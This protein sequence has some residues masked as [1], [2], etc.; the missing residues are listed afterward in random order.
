MG[1]LYHECI[2]MRV[3]EHD[4]HSA[5]KSESLIQP[6]ST[7][8]I[9][10]HNKLNSGAIS[11]AS[12]D[13]MDLF[14]D[15]IKDYLRMDAC[16][17]HRSKTSPRTIILRI[18]CPMIIMPDEND[19]DQFVLSPMLINTEGYLATLFGR[20]NVI[21]ERNAVISK[22]QQWY[23][24][25]D[26]VQ[27]VMRGE[28]TSLNSYRVLEAA[29]EQQL[30]DTGSVQH[31][32]GW[33][34]DRIGM[35]FG[36]LNGDY[37]YT[38]DGS[39]VDVYIL[40]TG[41]LATHV[42][43]E[44][45][46]T[47]LHSAIMDNIN[48]DCNGHGTHVAGIIGAKTYGVAK[49]ARLYGVRVLNCSGDGTV[50]DILE[51]ADVI[52]ERA[53]NQAPRRAVINLSLGGD[54][55]SVIDAMTK[56]LKDQGLV[57]VVAAGNSGSDACHFSP[58]NVGLN[59]VILTVGAS[60]INDHRPSWSNYGQCVSISAP[61][62][63]IKSTWYTGNTATMVL[64]GTSMAGPAVSGVAA[65]V[66]QQD[67]TLSVDQTNAIIVRWATTDV[68]TGTTQVGGASSCL[69]S[70][71]DASLALQEV[72]MPPNHN[73]VPHNS[74]NSDTYGGGMGLLLCF[75]VTLLWLLCLA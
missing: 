74:A 64:D 53:A 12:D 40:D 39:D 52:L 47:F 75:S 54:K 3:I 51:G 71:I 16:M 44:G 13:A 59:N 68:I 17:L 20:D 5:M 32:A 7:W 67:P 2:G 1:L 26:H 50:D 21:V 14:L 35:R 49:K 48:T 6:E 41:I 22:P 70:L 57:V 66:L 46:A 60:N 38:N 33:N 42:E 72:T 24:S 4:T 58:S 37:L 27:T 29:H 23:G 18:H 65:L 28:H 61:G 73:T 55:S 56:A 63:Q 30:Y 31:N 36:L 43:F 15:H 62:A 34:L 69:Y 9:V 19:E 8:L 10:I 11:L 25:Y 45:R